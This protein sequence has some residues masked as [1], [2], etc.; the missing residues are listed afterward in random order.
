[1]GYERT[2][3]SGPEST[4]A[5]FGWGGYLTGKFT[6]K[7]RNALQ[8]SFLYGEGVANY[9]NDGG[10]DV[11]GNDDGTDA[12]I[13]P[14]ASWYLSYLIMWSDEYSTSLGY[15]DVHQENTEFQEDDAFHRGQYAYVNLVRHPHE[16]LNYGFE[17]LWGQL[18]EKDRREGENYRIQFSMKFSF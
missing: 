14:L 3:I 7:G 5:E 13:L 15:S 4:G 17:F 8:F 6:V 1:M 18:D 2:D 10:S 16:R 12:E 9:I 11:T